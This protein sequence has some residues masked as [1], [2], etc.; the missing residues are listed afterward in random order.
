MANFIPRLIDV[1]WKKPN[2]FDFRNL[3][4]FF[5]CTCIFLTNTQIISKNAS[6]RVLYVFS[7]QN[8][9]LLY[10]LAAFKLNEFSS[11]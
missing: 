1:L 2:Y 11:I 7:K 3:E 6:E 5:G 10:M 4:E 8:N 9:I